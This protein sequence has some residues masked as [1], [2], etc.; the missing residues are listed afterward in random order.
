MEFPI[1]FTQ[2]VIVI[3]VPHSP[4]VKLPICLLLFGATT[5]TG[6]CTFV[7]PVS[8]ILKMH[9]GKNLYL[10][11]LQDVL[12]KNKETF[13]SLKL[14]ALA[15]LVACGLLRERNLLFLFTKSEYHC[16]LAII[17]GYFFSLAFVYSKASFLS[18]GF[19][20]P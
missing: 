7:I 12:K 13:A 11:R 18:C 5:L 20:S 6:V 15:K 3:L 9:S 10:M 14:V 1:A 4:E 19:D 17:P 16:S 2:L 8:S